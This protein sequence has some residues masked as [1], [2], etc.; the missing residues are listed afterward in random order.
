M[1]I[2]SKNE[3]EM[4]MAEEKKKKKRKNISLASRLIKN[5]RWFYLP[6]T[7]FHELSQQEESVYSLIVAATNNNNI[8][9]PY[10]YCHDRDNECRRHSKNFSM[11]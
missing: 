5:T 2:Y 11:K 1:T 3:D 9:H 4:T 6:K 7:I 10:I 8:N